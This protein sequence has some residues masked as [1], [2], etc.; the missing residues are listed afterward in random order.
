MAK[1]A[2]DTPSLPFDNKM[3]RKARKEFQH[4]NSNLISDSDKFP[5]HLENPLEARALFV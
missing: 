4:Q 5:F 2:K 1:R 3:P